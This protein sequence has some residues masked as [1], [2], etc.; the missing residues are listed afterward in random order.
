M[1]DQITLRAI[2]EDDHEF[3][4]RVYASTR[5]EELAIVPWSQAEKESFLRQQ[6][7]AQ[8]TYYRQVHQAA[9]H[10]VILRDGQ[11]VGRLYL[12][13]RERQIDIVDIA[14]LPEFRGQGIGS[15]LL[16]HILR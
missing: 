1:T 2:H 13:R 7:H 14:L 16:A 6:F 5:E 15:E 9:S 11:P 3:L 10:N 4:F 8:Q 12:N